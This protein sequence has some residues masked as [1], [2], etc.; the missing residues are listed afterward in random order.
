[1]PASAGRS[2]RHDGSRPG[3]DRS[4]P[5]PRPR[6]SRPRTS[7]AR[8]AGLTVALA[9][10]LGTWLVW[11][12]MVT[13]W[14]GQRVEERVFE[15]ADRFQD[16]V[17]HLVE[18]VLLLGSPP[19]LA[20]G[21]LAVCG[22]GLLRRRR[23]AAALAAAVILGSN[24]TT[25][26]I[27]DGVFHRTGLVGEWN[28]DINTLPSGHVT[29]V[30]A[31]WAAL[32][33]VTPRSR[34]PATALAGA[35]ATCAMGLATVA[36]RWHR[37]SDVVAAVL[38]VVSWTALV[39]ALAPAGWAGPDDVGPAGRGDVGT[40]PVGV[41]L[42]VV[43]VPAAVLSVLA[44]A[45]SEGHAWAV[46]PWAGGLTAYAGGLLAVCAISAAAFAVLLA[47]SQATAR[48]GRTLVQHRACLP[49][50]VSAPT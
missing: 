3:P 33:L 30:A 32:L 44:A 27:K 23:A 16:V 5:G 34:R 22:I 21:F 7:T 39:C 9:A 38:V 31:A 36:D 46:L 1:M 11:W 6:R 26:V 8:L 18:P 28:R 10:A 47:V 49:S 19:W 35:A 41:S 17:N 24:L 25:Q 13:T 40:R 48:T 45:A 43:A 2:A 14:P 20:A 15:T 12:A 50:N 42:G 37:P 4:T 29:V